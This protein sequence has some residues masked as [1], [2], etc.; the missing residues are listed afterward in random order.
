MKKFFVK[1]KLA[2]KAF[3]NTLTN[4]EIDSKE[5]RKILS[6]FYNNREYGSNVLNTITDIKVFD[7][8]DHYTMQITTHRPGILIGKG[9]Y[10]ID[11]MTEFINNDNFEKPIKIDLQE[12]KLWTWL[13]C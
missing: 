12:S 2:F 13:Y 8:G 3:Y 10:F 5:F 6:L 7:K 11:E 4:P 1:L 9:G